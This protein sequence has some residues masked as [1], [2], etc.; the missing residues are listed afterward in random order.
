MSRDD[1]VDKIIPAPIHESP[2]N[3]LP[4]VLR[5]IRDLLSPFRGFPSLQKRNDVK[6]KREVVPQI[7]KAEASRT[8]RGTTLCAK[9]GSLD[10]I[11]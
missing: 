9:I 8:L 11:Q 4:H 6:Y 1:T 2:N 5:H 3:L 7:F 10:S